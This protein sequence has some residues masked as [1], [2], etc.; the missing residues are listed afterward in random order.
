MNR[1]ARLIAGVVL[2]LV[3]SVAA[4]ATEKKINQSDM[5][6]AVQKT[7][8]QQST[9]AT[10]TGYTKDKVEGQ[11][12]YQ[13]NLLADGRVKGVVIGSD[14]TVVSVEEEV[15]WDQVP[16]NVQTN[17]T[18]VTGKGK[19]GNVSTVT[20]Q[21]KIVAYKAVLDTNGVRDHV[22]VKPHDG[23]AETVPSTDSKK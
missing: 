13:M 3:I 10:V 4:Q 5:P 11:I 7:A 2:G 1:T 19:L 8:E 16:A 21:G 6:A 22:V 15:A 14:G 18:N 17:F 20:K 9:G 23:P 12:V